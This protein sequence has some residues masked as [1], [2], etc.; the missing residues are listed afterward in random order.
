MEQ[1][2]IDLK[3]EQAATLARPRYP[4]SSLA[5]LFF[6]SMDVLTGRRTTLAKARLIEMFAGVPYHAWERRQYVIMT[7]GYRNQG[8]VDE[9]RTILAWAREAREN[10]LWHLRV[11]EEKMHQDH[12]PEPWYLRAPIPQAMMAGYAILSWALARADIRAAFLF[13]AEFEDH[14]EHTYAELVRDHPEWDGVPAASALANVRGEMASWA[15]VVRR[16]ALDERDHMNNSLHFGGRDAWIVEYDG[17]PVLAANRAR[18]A[19]R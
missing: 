17:M 15:D 7:K 4:Y 13:N 19:R 18:V 1:P 5:R 3:R 6:R 10:E 9:A 14:A 8:L 2:V 12:L 16:I 11:L